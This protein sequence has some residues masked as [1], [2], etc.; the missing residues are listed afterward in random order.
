MLR[1]LDT[2]ELVKNSGYYDSDGKWIESG[3]PPTSIKC[4]IQPLRKRAD[5]EN[6]PEGKVGR[7]AWVVY[8]PLSEGPVDVSDHLT[9]QSG[10]EAV[11]DGF[12]CE[13]AYSEK[14]RHR[15]LAHYKVLFVRKNVEENTP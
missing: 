4:N 15:R 12:N 6:L 7:Q 10:D 1:Y 2:I 11:I 13:A 3:G 14:W 8:V 5:A 9:G